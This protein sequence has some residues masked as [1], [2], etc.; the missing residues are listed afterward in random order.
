MILLLGPSTFWCADAI[1]WLARASCQFVLS[2]SRIFLKY[3]HFSYDGVND[4][5]M[6]T[7]QS[8]IA[9]GGN[10]KLQHFDACALSS[11]YCIN[12]TLNISLP[13][14]QPTPWS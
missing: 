7:K 1:C 13:T 2:I 9:S 11:S 4:Q 10:I 6:F 3:G 14:N 8:F 12:T 5:Q